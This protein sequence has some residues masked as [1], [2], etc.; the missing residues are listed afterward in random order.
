MI[1]GKKKTVTLC[2]LNGFQ[3]LQLFESF[4]NTE[5]VFSVEIRSLMERSLQLNNL[6]LKSRLLSLQ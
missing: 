5:L 6:L 1:E 2:V 4:D 3:L